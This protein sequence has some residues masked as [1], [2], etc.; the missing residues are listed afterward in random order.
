MGASTF[1]ESVGGAE[2]W[3]AAEGGGK[4]LSSAVA[5]SRWRV[6]C[7]TRSDWMENTAALAAT[8]RSCTIDPE[9]G[10]WISGEEE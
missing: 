4:I 8:K 7:E 6:S 2:A 5:K 1:D 10:R 3:S 9:P